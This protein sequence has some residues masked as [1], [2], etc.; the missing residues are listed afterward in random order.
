VSLLRRAARGAGFTR[1]PLRRACDRVEA[2]VTLALLTLYVFAAPLLAWQ[3]GTAV[4]RDG[5]I[6]ERSQIGYVR[7]VAVLVE[8][9]GQRVADTT[10]VPDTVFAQAH[11]T[12]PTGTDRVGRVPARSGAPAGTRVS[13]WVDPTGSR[14]DQPRRREQTVAL[15]WTVSAL[16]P[17]GLLTL[18]VAARALVR[19][20]LDARRLAEWERQWLLVEPR[21][22]GRV[23]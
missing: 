9:A 20:V 14:V 12:S 11:W 10:A 22:S 19:R 21:W 15:T 2:R 23:R 7:V 4:Y 8:P 16:V 17:L 1:N 6:T 3:A 5:V 18:L 13:I